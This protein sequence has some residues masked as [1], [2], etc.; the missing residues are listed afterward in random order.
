[1]MSIIFKSNVLKQKEL[2]TTEAKLAPPAYND[3]TKLASFRKPT[4]YIVGWRK[5]G[6]LSC[7][8]LHFFNFPFQ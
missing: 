8:L 4:L 5:C 6:D 3:K 2:E 7:V 1:M